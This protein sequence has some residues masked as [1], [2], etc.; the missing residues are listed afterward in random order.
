MALDVVQRLVGRVGVGNSV[1]EKMVRGMCHCLVLVI[2]LLL[3]IY[4]VLAM[5]SLACL[6]DDLQSQNVSLVLCLCWHA[7][8]VNSCFVL[9]KQSWS[10]CRY[11]RT[12]P[13]PC[14]NVSKQNLEFFCFLVRLRRQNIK[15]FSNP[16][17]HV[18]ELGFNTC[19]FSPRKETH[20]VVIQHV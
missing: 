12:N 1:A 6:S 13:C 4:F 18:F 19:T 16:L 11:N 3:V 9:E 10:A 8:L 5:H 2:Y 20:V 15:S 7:N 14:T 17:I